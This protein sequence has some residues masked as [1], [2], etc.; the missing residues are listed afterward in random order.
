MILLSHE[1]EDLPLA[2]EV[3]DALPDI[4]AAIVHIMAAYDVPEAEVSVTLTDN[5][6]IQ[7]LNRD[8]RGLDA[9]TDV[10]S[11]ALTESEEPAS[12]GAPISLGDI[13]IS[14][15]RAEEQAEE[16]GHSLRR[17]MVFLTVH[18]MLHLL[19]YDHVDEADREEMEQ[20]QR[21]IMMDLGIER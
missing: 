21:V 5:V 14:V 4:K 13:V 3:Q 12:F 15:E 1:P 9:P 16:Y 20:E 11:F 18:A 2:E 17:E 7:A 8:Y 6:H 19:G 10:L